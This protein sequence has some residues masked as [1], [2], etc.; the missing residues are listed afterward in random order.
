MLEIFSYRCRLVQSWCLRMLKLTQYL[1][2]L[3]Q[4]CLQ[5]HNNFEVVGKKQGKKLLN[6]LHFQRCCTPAASIDFP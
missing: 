2:A 6:V 4:H 5:H 1:I 3:P